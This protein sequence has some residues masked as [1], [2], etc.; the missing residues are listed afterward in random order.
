MDGN[1]DVV[2]G[3]LDDMWHWHSNKISPF[4]PSHERN[5]AK[6]EASKSPDR[7]L[8]PPRITNNTSAGV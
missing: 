5:L 6:L 8:S 7:T 1:A 3:L 4:D 2:W